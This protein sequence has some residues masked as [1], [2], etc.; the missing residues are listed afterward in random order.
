VTLYEVKVAAASYLEK[1]V[2]DLIQHDVDLGLIALN[3]VRQVAELNNDFNFTRKLLQVEV[4]G[5]TGGSLDTAIEYGG[6]PLVTYEVKTIVDVGTFDVD[7]NFRPS[8][9]TT[10]S[11][12]LNTQRLD[13]PYYTPRYPTDAQVV[14]GPIGQQRFTFSGNKVYFFPRTENLTIT[15]GIEAYTFTP[16]WD[17]NDVDRDGTEVYSGPWTAKGSQY[18]QWASVIH[19]NHLFKGFVFRQ[20]GNLPPPQTLADIALA[21]LQTWD[22]FMYE[23]FRRHSR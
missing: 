10:T 18:L 6:D 17:E 9:W 7:G 12:S 8:E 5:V 23:Q 20:E 11:D 16:D 3:H 2:N 1:G 4:D 13:S 19:L 15:L 21:S 14:C 22:T